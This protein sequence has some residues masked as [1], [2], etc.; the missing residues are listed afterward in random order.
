[1]PPV[2]GV[3]IELGGKTRVLRFTNRSR[4]R[5]ETVFGLTL[6]QGATQGGLQNSIVAISRLLWAASLHEEPNLQADECIDWIDAPR[7]KE[8]CDALGLAILQYFGVDEEDL[9]G[10]PE[11]GKDETATH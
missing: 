1:M 8:I 10:E 5:L 11:E 3:P 9:K 2:E 6:S 7:E 4:A